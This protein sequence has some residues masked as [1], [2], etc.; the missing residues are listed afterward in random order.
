[1]REFLVHTVNTSNMNSRVNAA[2]CLYIH[3]EFS[4]RAAIKRSGGS[5]QGALLI[6]N[7]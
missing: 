2:F 4:D 5:Q 7:L 1:M 3:S 6:P